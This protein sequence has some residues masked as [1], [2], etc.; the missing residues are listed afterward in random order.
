MTPGAFRLISV[1]A[2]VFTLIMVVLAA[3]FIADTP[4]T[5]PG[6]G[7][8]EVETPAPGDGVEVSYTIEEGASAGQVARELE[9]LGVI[10]SARQFEALVRLM[11]VGNQL[12]SGRYTLKTGMST[13]SAVHSLLVTDAQPIVR[14]TFPEG[15]RIEEMAIIA[16]EAGLGTSSQFMTAVQEAELPAG[17]A[18]SLPGDDLPEG[19]E[20]QGYLFPA[21]YELAEDAPMEDL[22]A[23]MI[24]TMDERFTPELRAAAA[25]QGLNP[26]EALTLA[27]IVEREAVVPEERPLIAGVFYNRIRENDFIGADPTTQYAVSLDPESVREYGYWKAGLTQEDLD[28]PSPY[29]TRSRAGLPP[30][31]ITNPSIESIEA[32]AMPEETDFYYFVA[33]AIEGDGSHVFAVTAGKH[34]ANIELYGTA[35]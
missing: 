18:E 1:A 5:I 22:V 19:R 9:G 32:V 20:L 11:G 25:E 2:V 6:A 23:M 17:L 29:N 12:A 13:P 8:P 28:N 35:E 30:G 33:N 26:H 14:V 24:R 4:S 15:I 10:R 16:E 21:T 34:Q 3:V 7:P 31:P 27:S